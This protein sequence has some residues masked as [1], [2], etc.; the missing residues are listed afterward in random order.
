MLRGVLDASAFLAFLQGEAGAAKVRP[1]FP[2]AVSALNYSE[3]AA[4][5]LLRGKPLDEIRGKLAE[6]NSKIF[7]FDGERAI[8]AATL[9]RPTLHLGLSLADRA[10]IA[11]GLELR[12][13]VYTADRAWA[14]IR[15][16]G[17]IRLI[18]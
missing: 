7:P 12:L 13:P 18:R 16:A 8:A 6:L 15:N 5:L 3:V 10:C 9:Q 4:Y 14:D 2:A 17:E 1:A 11:L